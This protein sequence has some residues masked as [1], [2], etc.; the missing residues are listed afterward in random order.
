MILNY[1]QLCVTFLI[2]VIRMLIFSFSKSTYYW[3]LKVGALKSGTVARFLVRAV[4]TSWLHEGIKVQ[5][6]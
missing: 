2:E 4:G 5:T 3:F 1:S 6:R